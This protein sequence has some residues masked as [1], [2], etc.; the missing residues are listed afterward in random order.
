MPAGQPQQGQ[1][2]PIDNQ[3][4]QQQAQQLAQ[5]NGNGNNG[6]VAAAEMEQQRFVDE[7]T[8]QRLL[9]LDGSFAFIEHVF[10]TI[11]LNF[12]FNFMFCEFLINMI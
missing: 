10:W 12:V 6:V 5:N 1:Q 2:P 3:N 8:W 4:Q 11:S 7:L 9:G